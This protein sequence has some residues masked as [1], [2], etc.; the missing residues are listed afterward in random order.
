MN[1]GEMADALIES[2]VL[3]V[4]ILPIVE[5]EIDEAQVKRDRKN[6]ALREKRAALR[7]EKMAAKRPL[8]RRSAG[9]RKTPKMKT[10][11]K[12]RSTKSNRGPKGWA[13]EDRR[14]DGSKKWGKM[15]R[16]KRLELGYTQAE[17][18]TFFGIKQPHMCNLEKGTFKP[19]DKVKNLIEAKFFKQVG[20][21]K[22]RKGA[23]KA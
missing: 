15:V 19:G 6:K 1:L 8:K 3:Q 23:P 9:P 4:G 7:A 10:P 22:P 20:L 18:A 16:A 5:S 21:G 12:T 17:F 11:A 13:P 14:R 2:G